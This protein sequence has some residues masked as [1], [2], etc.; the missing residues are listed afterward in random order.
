MIIIAEIGINHNGSIPL[1]LE[2]IRQAKIA[3][4]DIV[5]FQ[6]YSVDA[7][8][9]PG[10]EDP[11]PEI[12][13][14]VKK[15]ELSF[16]DLK[17]LKAFCEAEEIGFMCSIFD[18]ERLNWIESLGVTAHKIASRTSKLNPSLAQDIA[19]C[20]KPTYM[21]LGFNAPRL[22]PSYK[23]VRYLYCIA[24]YPT[25][26][27]HLHLPDKFGENE[28][29]YGFSDHSF[30]IEASLVAVARGA[31]VIEKHFTLNKA[32]EGPDHVCSIEPRELEELVRLS[33]RFQRVI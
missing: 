11:L 12:H 32:A 4:A 21:S 14:A 13:K 5:K 16:D 28:P 25:P 20:N 17:L 29:F 7:L 3:G 27:E 10:G 30:G 19:N 26:Y 18:T 24:E 23:N 8:F 22:N 2:M 15:T 31:Q 6:A 1:A 9:G 33:R